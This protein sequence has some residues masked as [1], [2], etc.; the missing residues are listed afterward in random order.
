LSAARLYILLPKSQAESS[1]SRL[2]SAFD[3]E[4]YPLSLSEIDEDQALYE[5]SLYIPAQADIDGIT[6]SFCRFG[7]LSAQDVKIEILPDIDW[8][9]HALDGL[10]PV[11]VGRFF[12]HGSHDRS[13]IQPHNLAIE[14]DAGQAFGTG[15]H[16]TTCG[17]LEM[18]ERIMRRDHPRH[19]LDLGTGSGVLAIAAAK[20]QRSPTNVHAKI[21]A[22][23]IDPIAT[24]VARDNVR[25]NG[26]APRIECL[27]AAGLHH[28]QFAKLAPFDLII[29]NILARPLMQLA[30]KIA[31]IIKKNGSVILSGLLDSQR[32]NVLAA[33]RN[34]GLYHQASLHNQGWATLHLK[35]RLL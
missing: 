28:R 11:R 9:R 8:V 21:L 22:S 35:K 31:P 26:V 23:D 1:F 17:C 32:D 30:P 5:I 15:H 12:I 3:E 24:H 27:T 20:K 4:A 7:D 29:A 25:L 19:V 13:H 33:F 6:S 10:A 2:E 14:I 16:G 34:Q 18:I